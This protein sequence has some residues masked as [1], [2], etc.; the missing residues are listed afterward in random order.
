[1]T[2]NASTSI[3][4][5]KRLGICVI[6]PT[7]NNA[8]TVADV[9]DD[10]LGYCEDVIVVN[11]GCTDDTLSRLKGKP[12]TLIG[13]EQN[14]GKGHALRLGF[15]HARKM[16]FKRA[17]TIDSDGQHYASDMPKFIEASSQRP[18]EIIMGS[19]NIATD[20]MPSQNTFAN[21]FSNFWFKVHTGISLPD[22]QTGYRLYPLD[23]IY[24]LGLLTSRYE[25][26]LELLVFAAWHGVDIHPIKVGVYYPPQ[27]QRISHFRPVYDF[28]RI[29]ILNTILS[30]ASILYGH[31]SR[32]I[33][34]LLR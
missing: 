30:F 20:N 22:T 23:A 9:V 26:E 29:S 27:E 28:T 6:M 21:R 34:K 32:I 16:G 1:M 25:A 14:H 4:E 17:I 10:V 12:V 13:T 18:K 5:A 3:A 24:G 31:P 11:D 19:R 33:H 15:R 2:V 7:Y 8:G